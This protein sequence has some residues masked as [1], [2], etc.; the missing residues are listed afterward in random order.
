MKKIRVINYIIF[1]SSF[2][3]YSYLHH[4]SYSVSPFYWLCFL[5]TITESK[6]LSLPS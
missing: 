4:Y 2:I 1:Y 3:S 6:S 5:E